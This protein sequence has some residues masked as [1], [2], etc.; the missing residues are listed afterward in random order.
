MGMSQNAHVH[1]HD[2]M[3]KN[4]MIKPGVTVYLPVRAPFPLL[5]CC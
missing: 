5:S 2:F 4:N 1:K 3:R